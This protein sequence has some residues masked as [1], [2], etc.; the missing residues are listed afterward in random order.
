MRR[1]ILIIGNSDG[2]G[3]AVTRALVTRGDK[4]VG[5]SKSPSPLGSTGPRHETIDVAS[6]QYPDLLRRMLREE[7][8]FDACIYCA[9]I[10]SMLKLPDFSNE[11]RV[12][13]VNFTAM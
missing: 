12:V 3:A 8:G 13:D 7:G 5:I 4:V 10:G 2:I 6:Q 11:A 9:G 1:R